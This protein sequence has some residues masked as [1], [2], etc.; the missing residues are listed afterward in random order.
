[1][2][3]RGETGFRKPKEILDL[4]AAALSPIPKTYRGALADPNWRDAMI[5]EFTA[6]QNNHTWDLVPLPTDANVVTGKWVYRHKLHPDGSLD[7]YKPAGSFVVSLN[8]LVLILG[9]LL[10]LWSSLLLF[11]RCYLSLF[12]RIGP[13]TS[14]M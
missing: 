3:T 14:L 7:G 6:L 10:V 2:V 4:H 13:F 1:M 12:L 5:E 11:A 8:D 9:R